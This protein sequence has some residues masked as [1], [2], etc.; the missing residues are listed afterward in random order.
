MS[1]SV[2]DNAETAVSIDDATVKLLSQGFRDS[3][4]QTQQELQNKLQ[5]VW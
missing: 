2:A 3:F 4:E 5:E 1:E